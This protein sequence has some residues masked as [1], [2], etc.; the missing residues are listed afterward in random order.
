MHLSEPEH[1]ASIR[2]DPRIAQHSAVPL[3]PLRK[4]SLDNVSV[5]AH[6]VTTFDQ[7]RYFQSLHYPS[8][9]PV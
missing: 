5:F 1:Y 7:V 3:L 9:L 8:D 4:I 6:D 2:D